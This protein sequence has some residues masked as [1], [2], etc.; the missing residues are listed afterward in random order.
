MF[1]VV[2]KYRYDTAMEKDMLV[3]R[4]ALH[5]MVLLRRQF[6]DR[7]CRRAIKELDAEVNQ[8]K[9]NEMAPMRTFMQ[10]VVDWL[11]R[12]EAAAIE[13]QA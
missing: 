13:S 8:E 1:F 12:E 7:F 10:W 2:A 4:E 6:Y 5:R 11:D 9:V 3:D